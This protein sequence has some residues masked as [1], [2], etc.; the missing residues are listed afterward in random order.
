MWSDALFLFYIHHPIFHSWRPFQLPAVWWFPLWP[1]YDAKDEGDGAQSFGR[2]RFIHGKHGQLQAKFV[3]GLPFE[4]RSLL[5]EC[6][7]ERCMCMVPLDGPDL[8]WILDGSFM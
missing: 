8:A 2:N 3:G 6:C 4:F 7:T 5:E 1:I